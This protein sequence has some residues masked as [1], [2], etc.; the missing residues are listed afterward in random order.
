MTEYVKIIDTD[1]YDG[2][3]PNQLQLCWMDSK[4]KAS[5]AFF[6]IEDAQELGTD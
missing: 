4:G 6:K 1:N 3:Y 5:I 2:D